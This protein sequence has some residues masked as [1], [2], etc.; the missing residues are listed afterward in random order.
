[1]SDL[2]SRDGLRVLVLALA[3]LVAI[4]AATVFCAWFT[5]DINGADISRISL[6]LREVRACTAGGDCASVPM[7]MIE[8][9]IY[10]T[11]A[12]L[13]FWTAVVFAL[14]V[15][16][17]GGTR[18][19]G[20]TPNESLIKAGHGIGSLT[21]ATTVAAGY[22]FGPNLDPAQALSVGFDFDRGWG[23]LAMLAGLV[24]GQLALYYTRERTLDDPPLIPIK[25]IAP[26]APTRPGVSTTPPPVS[27]RVP[28][29]IDT[30]PSGLPTVRSKD[31]SK[32]P[33]VA[34]TTTPTTPP[35]MRAL[36]D[37]FKGKIQFA[38]VT[39]D[40]TVAGMD[41]RREDGSGVLV[42]WRDVVGLVVRRLPPELDGH[43]FVDVVSTAGM[44]LRVLP[45][46]KMTGEHLS[47]DNEGRA[48]SFLKI[49][50]PRCTEAK[51]DR[52]TQA[53]LD[54]PTKKPAQL[55]SKD[56]LAKHDQALA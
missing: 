34:R 10:P 6:D 9:S 31:P 47:G 28:L 14:I 38:V 53:F 2:T 30:P 11:L 45:W 21:V 26:R 44:T 12:T 50:K 16:Y 36:A 17:Q 32:P 54:D 15:L 46:S 13:T 40:I 33:A 37:Q 20:G 56:M 48:R 42:M 3:S 22:V 51:L 5:V 43:P 49:V 23:P 18:V 19:L 7:S 29:P 35:P 55:P 4:A 24:F 41:A 39:G 52:A 8:G 27:T 25:P 1:M